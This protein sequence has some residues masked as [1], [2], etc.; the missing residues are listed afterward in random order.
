MAA[1]PL[2]AAVAWGVLLGM[3]GACVGSFVAALAT[4]WPRGRSIVRGR[5]AC[6]T[7]GAAVRARDLVPLLSAWRL[8][9]RCR[10]CRAAIP[11]IHWQ[12]ELAGTWIGAA[13][14]LVAG[15]PGAIAGAVC[16]W[17]LLALAVLDLVA[18]WLPDRLT[19]TLA[20]TGLVLGEGR[21]PDRAI[22]GAVGFGALWLVMVGYRAVRRR[23]GLGGGDPKLFGAIGCW[24][25]WVMLPGVLV[26]AGLAGLG[27]AAMLRLRRRAVSGATP[28]PFGALIAGAG[29]AA[30]LAMIGWPR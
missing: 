9:G 22:G 5:S 20:A 26:V 12:V 23:E 19:A 30:W 14:G 16:G 3:V 17:L 18:W 15:G 25:G 28:L 4:R 6:D 13:A 1:E 24:L 10:A 29:Y 11:P 7:C 2:L 21:L 8:G 27:W